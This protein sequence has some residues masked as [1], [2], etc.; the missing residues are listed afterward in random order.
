[1]WKEKQFE[2]FYNLNNKNLVLKMVWTTGL[3]TYIILYVNEMWMCRQLKTWKWLIVEIDAWPFD[4]QGESY[5]QNTNGTRIIIVK[6]SIPSNQE[7]KHFQI[8]DIS[9]PKGTKLIFTTWNHKHCGTL[10]SY[11]CGVFVL[12][13]NKTW[14]PSQLSK[15]CS[16]YST[17]HVRRNSQ[18]SMEGCKV[19]RKENGLL[20]SIPC[21]IQS[22]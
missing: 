12:W 20:L 8:F 17:G 21:D 16:C 18:K 13:S 7:W 1:M 19:H 5:P 22:D 4:N 11:M 3:L 14:L 2:Q 10:K 9:R 15:E 6:T